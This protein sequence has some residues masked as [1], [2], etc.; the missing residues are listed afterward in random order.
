MTQLRMW[1]AWRSSFARSAV[2]VTSLNKPWRTVHRSR[3][4]HSPMRRALKTWAFRNE[5]PPGC[6]GVRTF[7]K[8]PEYRRVRR[9]PGCV[10][11]RGM[12]TSPSFDIAQF[13]NQI[14]QLEIHTPQGLSGLLTKESRYVF[15][16]GRIRDNA[17]VSLVMPV[18]EE[19]YAS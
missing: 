11:G 18:R 5:A 14:R 8:N 2:R 12:N 1:S 15:N 3:A 16:Y 4:V 13:F 6:A 10:Q 17:A 7:L 9:T 19:S